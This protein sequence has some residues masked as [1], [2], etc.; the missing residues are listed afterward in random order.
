MFTWCECDIRVLKKRYDD[1]NGNEN[2]SVHHRFLYFFKAVFARP[3]RD[4]A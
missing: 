3:R 2:V 4:T 1:D